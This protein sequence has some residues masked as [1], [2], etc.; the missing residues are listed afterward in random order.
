MVEFVPLGFSRQ[1]IL[2]KKQ[3]YIHLVLI[4]HLEAGELGSVYKPKGCFQNHTLEMTQQRWQWSSSLCLA[5]SLF[6]GNLRAVFSVLLESF[7]I[8][9]PQ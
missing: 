3:D 2:G 8:Q 1:E 4:I 5:F 6:R 7:S 9:R